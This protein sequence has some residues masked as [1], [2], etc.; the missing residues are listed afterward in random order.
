MSQG[1]DRVLTGCEAELW[2]IVVES[3]TRMWRKAVKGVEQS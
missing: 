1:E 3:C 2:Q